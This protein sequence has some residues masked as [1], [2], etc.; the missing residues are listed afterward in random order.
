MNGPLD[1]EYL[2]RF[3]YSRRHR[4]ACMQSIILFLYIGDFISIFSNFENIQLTN[5]KKKILILHVHS[6]IQHLF[7]LNACYSN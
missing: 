2:I 4:D 6:D 5:L 7:E 1:P 3:L